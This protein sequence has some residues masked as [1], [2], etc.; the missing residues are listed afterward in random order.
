M[1]ARAQKFRNWLPHG[2]DFLTPEEGGRL[3]KL[4]E[5]V[6]GI[7]Q[8][9]GYQEIVP[10]TFDF[11]RTFLLTDRES[12]RNSLFQTRDADGENLAVRSDLTVQAIKAAANG[13]LGPDFPKRIS[14]VQPVF[15]DRSWGTGGSREITQAGIEIIGAD[16]VARFQEIL[17]IA[18]K[19]LGTL[20]EKQA[21]FLYGDV[22]FLNLLFERAPR[23][24]R[25]ELSE[26]FHN[27]DT[28]RIGGLCDRA[29]INGKLRDIF[30]KTP[31]TFGGLDALHK[32][33]DLC[34]G[35]EDLLG[36]LGDAREQENVVYDF[37]LVRELSYYTGPVFEAYVPGKKERA[38]SGGIY[39][40]LYGE[41][42]E[43]KRA[44]CG[45]AVNLSLF[46]QD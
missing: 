4:K 46:I 35:E 25:A 43:E 11:S 18:R 32:L 16:G 21:R 38:L 29:G 39:D 24:F 36:V 14:Y 15:Q 3:L 20:I 44:A 12:N 33:Q 45:F 30:M 23:P 28:E 37:S 10:P 19:L 7:F 13:R 34:S 41:F 27:K 40:E 42:A 2:F 8:E 31:L 6:R 26:A 5:I 17:E 1:P 22:R 9:A